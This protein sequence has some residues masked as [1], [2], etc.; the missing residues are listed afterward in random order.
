MKKGWGLNNRGLTLIELLIGISLFSMIVAGVFSFLVMNIGFS[1][2]AQDEVY[3]QEQVRKAVAAIT[4]LALDKE[5]YS[6]E[7]NVL[8][9]SKGDEQIAFEYEDSEI[10]FTGDEKST[11]VARDIVQFVVNEEQSE[12]ESNPR[13]FTIKIK[14]V[15]NE[16]TKD[17]VEFELSNNIFLRN[18]KESLDDQ[19]KFSYW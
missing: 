10:T 19:F 18:Y 6:W 17:E 4:D 14:G 7:N 8:T 2:V 16:G 5:A 9:L 3:I 12:D 15:K 13:Y 1:N 11:V